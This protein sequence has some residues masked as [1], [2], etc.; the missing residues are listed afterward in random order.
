MA[1]K[2]ET[3]SENDPFPLLEEDFLREWAA[4]HGFSETAATVA[5]TPAPAA[6]TDIDSQDSDTWVLP[7]VPTEESDAS[8]PRDFETMTLPPRLAIHQAEREARQDQRERRI[9]RVAVL[10][11]AVLLALWSKLAVVSGVPSSTPLPG[12]PTLYL[13]FKPWWFGP[14]YIDLHAGNTQ[15][16][17]PFGLT[18]SQEKKALTDPGRIVLVLARVPYPH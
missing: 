11:L 1:E 13:L 9:R 15:G 6:P 14:A 4:A 18:A 3:R 5:P 16:L 12:T 17:Y 10:V 2:G 8:D 7:V